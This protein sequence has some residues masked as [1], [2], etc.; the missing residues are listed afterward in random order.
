MNKQEKENLKTKISNETQN[1]IDFLQSK[2]DSLTAEYNKDLKK[3][4]DEID[5][6][7]LQKDALIDFK[8]K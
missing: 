1:R 7:T 2:I 3:F 8:I 4:Q 6:L 5:S